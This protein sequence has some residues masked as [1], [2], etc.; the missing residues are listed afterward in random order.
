MISNVTYWQVRGGDWSRDKLDATEVDVDVEKIIGHPDYSVS[1]FGV[2]NDIALLKLKTS[3]DIEDS[4]E[5]VSK[6]GVVILACFH[7]I[8]QYDFF[9]KRDKRC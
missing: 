4:Y 5:S 7:V 1:P 8:L 3:F 6:T 2:E 9:F